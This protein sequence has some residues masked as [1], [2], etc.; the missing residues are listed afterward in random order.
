[1]TVSKVKL[2]RAITPDIRDE[3]LIGDQ[4]GP[5]RLTWCMSVEMVSGQKPPAASASALANENDPAPWPISNRTP[6]SRASSAAGR[7]R[8][9]PSM[10]RSPP[11]VNAWVTMSP[12]RRS[13]STSSIAG[14]AW[15]MWHITRRPVTSDARTARAAARGP[16]SRRLPCPF[17]S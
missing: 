17:G 11:P 10:S 6:R 1:M 8:P 2:G 3:L 15:L 14:G 4:V 16:D 12:P 5:G 13:P 9:L 7:G